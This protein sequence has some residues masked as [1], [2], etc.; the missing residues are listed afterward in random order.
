[1]N[2]ETLL[3]NLTE[4]QRQYD[5]SLIEEVFKYNATLEVICHLKDVLGREHGVFKTTYGHILRG[6]GCPKCNGKYMDK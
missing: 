5:F 4:K 3:T 2:K 6:D 1:M